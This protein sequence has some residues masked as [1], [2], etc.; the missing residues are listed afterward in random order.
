MYS[1]TLPQLWDAKW[2]P[3]SDVRQGMPRFAAIVDSSTD[4]WPYLAIAGG[5]GLLI[6]WIVFGTFRRSVHRL[7]AISG[8]RKASRLVV[9]R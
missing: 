2:E 7:R 5:L 4:I 9:R 6:E 3:P 1:L 8:L